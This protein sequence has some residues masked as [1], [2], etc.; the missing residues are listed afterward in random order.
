MS[1][2]DLKA[3]LGTSFAGMTLGKILSALL[4]LIVCLIVIKAVLKLTTRLLSRSKLDTRVQKRLCAR[5]HSY[6]TATS[7]FF[8]RSGTKRPS[9]GSIRQNPPRT[10]RHAAGMIHFWVPR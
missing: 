3:L 2:L 8:K 5:S 4:T 7:A 1:A 9:T 10:G 6:Y